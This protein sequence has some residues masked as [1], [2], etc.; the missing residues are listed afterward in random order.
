[1]EHEELSI[2]IFKWILVEH[3]DVLVTFVD[4]GLNKDNVE[5]IANMIDPDKEYCVRYVYMHVCMYV[6]LYVC[7][8]VCMY[9]LGYSY[10]VD[11]FNVKVTYVYSSPHVVV[12][13]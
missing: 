12:A 10:E 1:M 11:G 9:V 2:L 3:L 8:Y 7:M 5:M 13:A 6:C 4:A